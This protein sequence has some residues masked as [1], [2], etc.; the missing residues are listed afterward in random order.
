MVNKPF[1][2]M[3]NQRYSMTKTNRDALP[4]KVPRRAKLLFL[5]KIGFI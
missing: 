5:S 1:S 4:T 3:S 2:K